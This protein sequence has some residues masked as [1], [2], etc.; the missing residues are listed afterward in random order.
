[1]A[2]NGHGEEQEVDLARY[3]WAILARWWLVAL[4]VALGVLAGYLISLGGGRL[5][6]ATAT[7]YLGAPLTPS[8]GAPV[9]SLQT[10][11]ATVNQI[12]RSTAVLR[13]V[14]E[15]VEVDAEQLRLA[16]ST[17]AVASGTGA[18]ATQTQLVEVSVRGPWR[19]QSA[20]AANLLAA[21]A[22]D[23]ISEYPRQKI[24]LLEEEAVSRIAQ[25]EGIE[26]RLERYRAAVETATDLTSAEQLVLLTLV[27][28]A[29]QERDQLAEE[30]REIELALT[31][32]R[33]LE[34][35]QL[36]TEAAPRKVSARGRGSSLIVGAV[37]GLLVGIVAAVAWEPVLSRIRRR[38]AGNDAEQPG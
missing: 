17:K 34:A 8:S 2:T 5:F 21:A 20:E 29:Q 13:D 23:R 4:G 6:E 12:V 28:D 3:G 33:E 25:L 26:E 11:P 35:A 36:V 27:D 15:R 18:R 24:A 9:Q 32:A 7:V 37:I 14:A 22:I 19:R 38:S 31:L 10:N 30:R 16:V 1:V